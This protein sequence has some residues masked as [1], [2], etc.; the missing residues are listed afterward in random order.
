[1]NMSLDLRRN[2]CSLASMRELTVEEITQVWGGSGPVS[3]SNNGQSG[4]IQASGA[5]LVDS[6]ESDASK[7][8]K[9]ALIVPQDTE[10]LPIG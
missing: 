7:G 10:P 1:M 2:A 8:R 3:G 5:D 6:D 4:T 9:N